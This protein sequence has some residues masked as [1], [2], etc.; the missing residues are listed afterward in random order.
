MKNKKGFTLVELIVV[1]AILGIL[2]L[3]LVPSFMGY[4]DD[5]KKQVAESNTRT[6]W[7]A[8]NI[9]LVS[10]EYKFNFKNVGELN[11]YVSSEVLK[12]L[13]TSFEDKAVDIELDDDGKIF[14]VSVTT[15]D[16]VCQTQ[17]GVDFTLT[18]KD[19]STGD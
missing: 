5:A 1:I 19:P 7:S 16:Y 6:A 3:F 17:N 10:A 8:A 14:Q 4:A 9:A 13:G 12:K 15:G 18:D 11:D 2:S